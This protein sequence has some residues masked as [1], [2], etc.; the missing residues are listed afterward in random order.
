MLSVKSCY[1]HYLRIRNSVLC[2]NML[3]LDLIHLLKRTIEIEIYI[4]M[5]SSRHKAI[6]S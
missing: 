3:F 2:I 6:E 4:D 5:Y 1:R